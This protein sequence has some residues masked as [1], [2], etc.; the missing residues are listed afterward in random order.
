MRILALVV[1]LGLTAGAAPQAQSPA[2][3]TG[4]ARIRGS[5]VDASTGTPVRRATMRLRMTPGSSTWTAITDGNGAFEFPKLPAGRFSLTATKGGFIT[6]GPGQDEPRDRARPIQTSAGSTVDL[7]PIAL[8]RGGVITGRIVD[9]YADVV[10]EI[11]VQ[12]YRAQYMQGM[13]RLVSVRSAQTNDIGQYRIYGL[14]PGTYYVAATAPA[15]DGSPLQLPE[16]ET[17]AVRGGAGLAPTFFPGTVSAEGAQRIEVAA[18]GEVPGVDFSLLAVRL[19]RISGAI[20]DSRGKPATAQ[21]VLLVPDRPDGALLLGTASVAE[22]DG[23]GRFTLENVSPNEYRLEVRA[24]AYFEALAQRGRIGQMQ[25]AD[26][27]EFASVPLTVT[28]EDLAG[29]SVRL[30]AGHHMTGRVILEG[31]ESDPRMLDALRVSVMPGSGGMSA[32]MLASH[33]PVADDGS[34]QVRGL[35]GRRFV[36]VSGLPGGWAL[37][38][39][40]AG[41]MDVTDGGIEILENLDGVEIVVTATPTLLSGVVTDAAGTL[42]PEAAVIIFPEARERRSG[43]HNRYVTTVRTGADGRFEVRGLPPATYVAI[44]VPH[45]QDGEWAERDNLDDLAEPATRFTLSDSGSATVALR[46]R[47][48]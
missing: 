1:A 40:R 35:M 20:V 2:Q 23:A 16:P 45:L 9:E 17:Q 18:G 46:L 4:T 31:A 33:A 14:Q 42:V 24:R 41:G 22:T 48:R 3:A 47:E 39:V 19:A 44:A 12:A 38:S 43:P 27:P 32:A 6:L 28:G 21:A 5:V 34:F 10:P 7:P 25:G 13:R 15:A 26:A 29:I 8:P 30:T 36:R 37:K 11:T